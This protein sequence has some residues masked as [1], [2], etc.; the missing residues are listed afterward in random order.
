MIAL[1]LFAGTGWGVACQQL[2]IE[3][4]GVEL[5]PEARATRQAAGMSTI[6]DDAWDGLLDEYTESTHLGRYNMLIASPPCQTFSMAGNGKGR[7]IMADIMTAIDERL[8]LD[9]QGLKAFGEK[10]D[11]R[12]ALVLVPLAYIARDL[13]TFVVLEQVPSVMP[14]WGA[15]ALVMRLLGYSVK[16]ELLH[17]EQ[18]GVPQTRTRAILVARRD[19]VEVQM[20]KPTHSRYYARQPGRLDDGVE[21]WVSMAEA[22]GWKGFT[23]G[24]AMGKGMVERHGERRERREDEPA[25][26]LRA[27]AGGMEPGGFVIRPDWTFSRPAT[28]IVADPRLGGPGRSEFVKGGVSRQDRPG[29][30]RLEARE[31]AMLQSYPADFPFQ[32]GKGKQFLQIGNAVPPLLGRRIIEAVIAGATRG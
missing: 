11:P 21:K 4:L 16:T 19:G 2:G 28:T 22:L 29:S 7:A 9:P 27:N 32:G 15:Y 23:A 10:H 18:Y 3:E 5:M 24:K 17:A 26:T 25:F 30:M 8:Y 13:P 31:A 14:I 20:P 1:D 12:T 6:F